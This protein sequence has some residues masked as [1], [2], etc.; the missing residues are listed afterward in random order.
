MQARFFTILVCL[1]VSH[2]AVA[3]SPG[4]TPSPARGW[5]KDRPEA[6]GLDEKVLAA[7]DPDLASGERWRIRPNLGRIP[8]WLF[9]RSRR[10]SGRL[11]RGRAQRADSCPQIRR[12]DMPC[13]LFLGL[14]SASST[15]SKETRMAAKYEIY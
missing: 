12:S 10:A 11:G 8:W 15:R 4:A 13:Q 5:A 1:A 14:T 6:V 9:D 7:F 2:L 3:Q